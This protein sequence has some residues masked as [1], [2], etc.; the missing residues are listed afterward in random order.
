MQ[1]FCEGCRKVVGKIPDEKIPADKSVKV[2]CPKCAGVITLG[3]SEP[4]PSAG[5]VQKSRQDDKAAAPG[6][7]PHQN[8][9]GQPSK[10]Q[11]YKPEFSGTAG[12]Y[13]RIWIVNTFLTIITLGIYAAWAKVRTRRY[14]YAHTKIASH[15]FDYL[16][17]PI[18]ILKGNLIV[19]G[20]FILYS[21]TQ[22][23]NPALTLLVVVVFFGIFPLLVFKSLRF[24]AHNSSYRNI[25]FRFLGNLGDSYQTYMLLPLTIPFTL[26]LM[27]P[28]WEFKRKHYF[29]DNVAFGKSTNTFAGQPKSFYKIYFFAFLMIVGFGVLASAGIGAGAFSFFKKAVPPAAFPADI[30]ATAFILLFVGYIFMLAFFTLV[31]QYIYTRMTNYCWNESTLGSLRFKS[32]IQ[33]RKLMWIRISNIMAIIVSL[34]LLA[35]WAKVRRTRYIL[36]NLE[37]STEKSLD[38]FAAATE[39]EE[40]A[41]GDAATDF[42]DFEIGL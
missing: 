36:D 34:G 35:P 17:D 29:F 32:T 20:G 16:A 38:H 40:N 28:Y 7:A 8:T 9:N 4:A 33:A 1:V 12:E 13:F 3:R 41:Y 21:S 42:F 2:K 11:R 24:N 6:P 31:Q 18:A 37:L 15:A 23:I 14:F 39:Q 30:P 22:F 25:R 26:G 5:I 19:G 27:I 10:P